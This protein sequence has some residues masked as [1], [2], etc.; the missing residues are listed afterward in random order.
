MLLKSLTFWAMSLFLVVGKV[1]QLELSK[2]E[3]APAGTCRRLRLL[4]T[5]IQL[6]IGECDHLYISIDQVHSHNNKESTWQ[7]GSHP[8]RSL[9]LAVGFTSQGPIPVQ[10]D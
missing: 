2:N 5:T 10:F 6:Q 3:L 4:Q 9:T 1:V 8:S 7:T